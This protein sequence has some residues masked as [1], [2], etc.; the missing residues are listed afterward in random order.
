MTRVKDKNIYDMTIKNT[1]KITLG[2]TAAEVQHIKYSGFILVIRV[3]SHILVIRVNSHT[4]R[5]EVSST[6]NLH[7]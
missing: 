7:Y 6:S 5:A 1:N 4:T 2:G 3:N